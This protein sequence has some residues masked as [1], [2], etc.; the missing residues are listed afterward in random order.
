VNQNADRT[1]KQVGKIV[2]G[3]DATIGLLLS[4]D[5]AGVYYIEDVHKMFASPHAV[6]QAMRNCAQQDGHQT[7][8]AYM[9]DPGS[10]GVSEA[11]ATSRVLDGFD[12]RFATA[13]GDK[14]TRAKPISA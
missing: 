12:V 11:Q 7:M 9:Q 8:V 5:S 13:T 10:A 1:R 3:P 4:R 2:S 6:E 14:E